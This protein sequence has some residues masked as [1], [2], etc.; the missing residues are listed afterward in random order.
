MVDEQ[1]SHR[2]R[3]VVGA[4]A[5]AATS[6][7]SYVEARAALARMLAGNRIDLRRLEAAR[8]D[9]DEIWLDLLSLPADDQLLAT[10]SDLADDHSLR[11][12]DAIQLASALAV[13]RGGEVVFA[14]WDTELSAAARRAGLSVP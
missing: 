8:H 9:L 12:Y 3:E 13:R 6:T 1:D 14:C 4:A 5:I 11:G 7:V 10:A 2:T